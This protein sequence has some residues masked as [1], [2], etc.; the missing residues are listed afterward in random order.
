[1]KSSPISEKP[2]L[3]KPAEEAAPTSGKL[4]FEISSLAHDGRGIAFLPPAEGQK[5]GKAVFIP[6]ALP[7]QKARVQ[8]GADR[9]SW[10]EA[11]LLEILDPGPNTA[12]PLCPQADKCGGCPLRKMPYD[13]QLRWKQRLL[14]DP[15]ERIGGL[16]REYLKSVWKG[17][18]PSPEISGH[19]NKIEL[20]FSPDGSRLGMRRR[21]SHETAPFEGCSIADEKARA[22]VKSFERLLGEKKWPERFWRFLVLR[23]DQDGEG[24]RRWRVLAICRPA[25]RS[26]ISQAREL[27]GA[28]LDAE[29]DLCSFTLESR[30][31]KAD[32]AKGEK[33]IFTAGSCGDTLSLPLGGRVFKTDAA[34]F[35]Q[36]NSGAG[37]KL[38][39]LV[40]EADSHCAN[41]SGLLDLYCGCGA[42]GLLIAPRYERC[43]GIELDPKAIEYARA[44][45]ADLP[46]CSFQAGDA[47]RLIERL[48]PDFA[49]SVSTVL[50]DPPRAGLDKKAINSILRLS[51]E[52][53]IMVSC[54]PATL[55]RDARLLGAKYE[56]KSL[57]GADLFP[58][59]PHVESVSLWKKK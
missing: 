22:I 12:P 41:K 10:H 33:R 2:A 1:M 51:P 7:G 37:E 6:G 26:V 43:I 27:A 19:R 29:P 3:N 30:K 54:N 52:N 4:I 45:A 31:D 39:D 13:E 55:A 58:H 11:S 49:R 20:A 34:S 23:S 56:L 28:L 9:G 8:L 21:A 24:G 59:T 14:L 18:E 46:H 35:F 36:V 47:A 42:P 48:P 16:D 15:L 17:I 25:A 57:A 44:N 53:L 38:A 5:R 40:K 32:I 50:A